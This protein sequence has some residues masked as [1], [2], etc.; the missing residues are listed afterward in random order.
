MKYL[1]AVIEGKETIFV[2]PRSVDHDRMAEALQAIRFGSERNWRRELHE[3]GSVI[4]AGFVENATCFGRS[5]TLGLDSR[6]ALDTA[7]LK[8]NVPAKSV[9]EPTLSIEAERV[10]GEAAQRSKADDLYGTVGKIWASSSLAYCR[11]EAHRALM[12]HRSPS[13]VSPDY[14][15]SAQPGSPDFD[16]AEA[17]QAHLEAT[18]SMPAHEDLPLTQADDVNAVIRLLRRYVKKGWSPQ[19]HKEA[20]SF[21]GK[22]ELLK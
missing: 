19:L 5:E 9:P 16:G 21:L 4:S 1:V 10:D 13:L 18:T 7:L 15:T 22:H 17:Y 3:E 20:Q 11:S 8:A 12:R 14:D 2:F 6:G